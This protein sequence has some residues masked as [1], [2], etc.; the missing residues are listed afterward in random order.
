METIQDI[1]KKQLQS[2]KF[3][4][5][6]AQLKQ[7]VLSHQDVQSFI[8][9]NA[10]SD[11]I[12]ENSYSQLFEYI[13]EQQRFVKTG[14]SQNEGF[15]PVL[16]FDGHAID[17][18]YKPTQAFLNAQEQKE[19]AKRIQTFE[20]PTAIKNITLATIDLNQEIK[21]VVLYFKEF[22]TQI[23]NG[24]SAKGAYLYGSFGVGKTHLI[25]ALA[26]TLAKE[27]F[28]SYLAHVPSLIVELKTSIQNN[29]LNEKLDTIKKM[30][31]LMLDDIGGESLTDWVRD[32]IF[33][34]IL[35]YRMRENLPTFF[36]SN[37][38]FDAL[39]KHFL[40]RQIEDER[41]A[42]RLMERVKFLAKPFEIAGRNR[43]N[44]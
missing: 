19:V 30:P 44:S 34:V 25:G 16:V 39:E 37:L 17:V 41:K 14:S 1:M 6:S 7:Q 31:I 42:I 18:S 23:K 43:R 2:P 36:T 21:D 15:E 33:M 26:G 4:E 22:L 38:S 12:V 3:Q 27:G 8:K 13:T 24:Q 40:G 20:M 32:D 28:S 5:R 35:D 29:T 11:D 10:I 9:E